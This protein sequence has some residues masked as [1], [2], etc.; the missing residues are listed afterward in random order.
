MHF[1]WITGIITAVLEEAPLV[2]GF[3]TQIMKGNLDSMAKAWCTLVQHQLSPTI[4][5]NILILHRVT[6][7]PSI[8]EG[9]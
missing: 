2:L 3:F 6:F 9:L 1:R 8:I 5:E 4:G 7:V